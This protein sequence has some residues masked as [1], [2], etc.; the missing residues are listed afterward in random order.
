LKERGFEPD[1]ISEKDWGRTF[2]VRDPEGRRIEVNHQPSENDPDFEQELQ[3]R[4]D[5]I[6]SGEAETIPVEQ[7]IKQIKEELENRPPRVG[8]DEWAS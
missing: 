4:I 8:P 5:E 6:E 3:R 2:V 1:A 7:A